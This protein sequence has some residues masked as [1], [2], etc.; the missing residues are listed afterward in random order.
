[1]EKKTP[2]NLKEESKNNDTTKDS[3]AFKKVNSSSNDLLKPE[4]KEL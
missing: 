2:A 1:M 4:S 3:I